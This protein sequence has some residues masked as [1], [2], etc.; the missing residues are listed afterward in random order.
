MST[1]A[2]LEISAGSK[3]AT[4]WA[5]GKLSVWS[6]AS[7]SGEGAGL[8]FGLQA[9]TAMTTAISQAG[10]RTGGRLP[11]A[12]LLSQIRATTSHRVWVQL[13]GKD[14]GAAHRFLVRVAGWGRP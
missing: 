13:S 11:E 14:A 4:S 1:S 8:L 10:A 9:T 6:A 3:S 7:G 12:C 5:T 2:A